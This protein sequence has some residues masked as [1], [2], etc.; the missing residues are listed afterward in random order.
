M[1]P[2]DYH[3]VEESAVRQL[4]IRGKTF[5]VP[6]SLYFESEAGTPCYG[7]V[8]FQLTSRYRAAVID[9]G[10]EHGRPDPFVL[11]LDVLGEILRDVRRWMPEAQILL[12]DVFH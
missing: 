1:D 5:S 6:V 9:D 2:E 8:G 7:Y 4:T 11:D 12:M 3:Y 10:H